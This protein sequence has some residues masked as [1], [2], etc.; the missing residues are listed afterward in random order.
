MRKSYKAK[1]TKV[2]VWVYEDEPTRI[3]I[4]DTREI[5]T[6]DK[7]DGIL[8]KLGLKGVADVSD[9]QRQSGRSVKP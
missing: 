7:L 6:D 1:P 8:E 9:R 3:K 5:F 2:S 4:T